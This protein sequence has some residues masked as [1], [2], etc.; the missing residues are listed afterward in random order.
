MAGVDRA[1]AWADRAI[2]VGT[3]SG[4]L[5]AGSAVMGGVSGVVAWIGEY[6]PV[7]WLVAFVAGA[8][9]FAITSLVLTKTYAAWV[10]VKLRKQFYGVADRTDPMKPHYLNERIRLEDL[11][12]P[13]DDIVENKT[14]ENCQ[15]IGPLNIFPIWIGLEGNLFS[16]VDHI[17]VTEDAIKELRLSNCRIF[18]NCRFI[19]CRIYNVSFLIGAASGPRV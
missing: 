10:G 3:S 1:I 18:R 4:A 11:L 15:I 17:L 5:W 16:S 7:G 12:P 8:L 13:G 14:F 2:T 6:G 9:A 19:K